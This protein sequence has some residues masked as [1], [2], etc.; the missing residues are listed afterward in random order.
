MR[1]TKRTGIHFADYRATQRENLGCHPTTVQSTELLDKIQTMLDLLHHSWLILVGTRLPIFFKSLNA[2]LNVFKEYQIICNKLIEPGFL[3]ANDSCVWLNSRVQDNYPNEHPMLVLTGT[4]AIISLGI[5][6]RKAVH[7][8]ARPG[9]L[10]QEDSDKRRSLDNEDDITVPAWVRISFEQ[11]F[12]GNKER[13]QLS[14][15]TNA[16]DWTKCSAANR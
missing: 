3:N 11:R 10:V 16:S 7:Q 2:V 14:P 15:G 8:P 13:V 6:R 9:F 4:G 5:V 1:E 12:M